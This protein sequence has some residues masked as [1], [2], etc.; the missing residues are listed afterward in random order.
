MNIL[1]GIRKKLSSGKKDRIGG[2]AALQLVCGRDKEAYEALRNVI[3]LQEPSCLLSIEETIENAT[4]SEKRG[5][6]HHE[7]NWTWLTAQRFL[8][9][10]DIEEVKKWFGKY[11]QLSG[12]KP[13]ILGATKRLI[14]TRGIRGFF[15]KILKKKEY[16]SDITERAVNKAQ[17]YYRFIGLK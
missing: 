5:D 13:P 17:E 15:E 8:Y 16:S 7:K 6:K 9:L 4:Q 11:E 1:M 3:L 14:K 10:G 12:S 2:L